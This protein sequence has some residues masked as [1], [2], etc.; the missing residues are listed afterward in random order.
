MLA[1]SDRFDCTDQ[2]MG[3]LGAPD[4]ASGAIELGAQPVA[5]KCDEYELL[6]RPNDEVSA[7]AVQT[8]RHRRRLQTVLGPDA[9]Q[10][11]YIGNTLNRE[12]G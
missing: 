2:H 10:T 8:L 4:W 11:G 1:N 5:Q 6:L 3:V 9:V 7:A 12:H